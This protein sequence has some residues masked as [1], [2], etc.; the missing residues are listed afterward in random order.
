MVKHN[1]IDLI[2][3]PVKSAEQL[4]S[5]KN[6]FTNVFDWKYTEWGETY[7]DTTDSGTS[8]G[9]NS[10]Q[11]QSM[12]LTVIYSEDLESTKEKVVQNGGTII[13]DTYT[14][15]GGRRFHFTEPN[16]NELAVWSE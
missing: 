7:S 11:G 8:N 13:L 14:F 2:E 15:P 5:T 3:F 16:G 10:D 4:N 6:F 12:P 9:I 1:Q